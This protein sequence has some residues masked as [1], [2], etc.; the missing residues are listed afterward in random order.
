[1]R[2]HPSYTY[3]RSAKKNGTEKNDERQ[4][5]ACQR[6]K[7]TTKQVAV[8]SPVKERLGK[9]GLGEMRLGEM[10]PNRSLFP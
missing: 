10:L 6:S 8:G 7:K 5:N 9:M 1:M 3:L 2:R 4:N